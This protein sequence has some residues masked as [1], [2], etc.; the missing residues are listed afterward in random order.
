MER[1]GISGIESRWKVY[2]DSSWEGGAP[3]ILRPIPA[4][5][6]IEG[7]YEIYTDRPVAASAPSDSS[8]ESLFADEMSDSSAGS[9]FDEYEKLTSC[10]HL[11][12]HVF[13]QTKQGRP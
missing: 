2:Q 11:Q 3:A 5:N 7:L 10:L 8:T 1:S 12:H 13:H 9:L 6:E 4:D